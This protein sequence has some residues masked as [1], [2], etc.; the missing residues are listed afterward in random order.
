M[1]KELREEKGIGIGAVDCN[2]AS[3]QALCKQQGVRGYPLMKAMV[4]GKPKPYNGL[5]ELE[6]MKEWIIGV[7][8]NRGTKGGSQKCPVGI[9]NSK[10]FDAVVP[11]CEAHF[12]A[13]NAKNAWLIIFYDEK[14]DAS[15][16]MKE[17]ANQAAADLGSDPPSTQKEHRK[18]KKRRDR[19]KELGDK[20]E[21]EVTLPEK[22]PFGMD[23]LAK[24]GGLCCD[25]AGE[26]SANFC[27]EILGEHRTSPRPLV[28]WVEKG[29]VEGHPGKITAQSLVELSLTKFGF[30]GGSADAEKPA[31]SPPS[32]KAAPP[33]PPSDVHTV[34]ED[35]EEEEQ[36]E[37]L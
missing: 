9:F 2:D 8:K 24:V 25:C 30:L 16:A 19:V 5:R 21:L 32:S 36:H 29:A 28:A 35:E 14:N 12:P 27:S 22:G 10:V 11:L 3:N 34:D 15:I 20:Y 23:A 7:R 1:A 18:Q 6:Q 37:E 26:D 33:S 4:G 31:A 17:R 13:D